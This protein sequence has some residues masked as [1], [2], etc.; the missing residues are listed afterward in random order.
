MVNLKCNW[1]NQ[2][3]PRSSLIKLWTQIW[4]SSVVKNRSKADRFLPDMSY[5][6]IIYI[7]MNRCKKGTVEKFN[8]FVW[9]VVV[10]EVGMIV[11]YLFTYLGV[12]TVVTLQFEFV[13]S[14]IQTSVRTNSKAYFRCPNRNLVV[15]TYRTTIKKNQPCRDK[16]KQMKKTCRPSP[17][18]HLS[19]YI[20]IFD[21]KMVKW[22][23]YILIPLIFLEWE[24]Y[25]KGVFNWLD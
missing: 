7:F 6:W 19:S 13:M 1:I 11:I 4:L 8:S 12:F 3:I 16:T 24:Q 2:S 22:W 18:F 15:T 21:W 17:Y 20:Y 14:R 5:F 9:A 23:N 25:Q 10:V